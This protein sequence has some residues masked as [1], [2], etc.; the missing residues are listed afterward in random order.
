MIGDEFE[1]MIQ[2]WFEIIP[3]MMRVRSKGR[4]TWFD[5]S[6]PMITI[7]NTFFDTREYIGRL[8]IF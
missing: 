4:D 7:L 5:L 3:D 1:G 2:Q 6:L 8:M